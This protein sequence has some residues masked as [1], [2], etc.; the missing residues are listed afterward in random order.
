RDLESQLSAAREELK[1]GK[2]E[3]H[4]AHE[5]M[6]CRLKAQVAEADR[7]LQDVITEA[8]GDCAVLEHQ[9][10][11]MRAVLQDTERQLKETKA[12]LDVLNADVSG[13]GEELK[14]MEHELQNAWAVE[15]TLNNDLGTSKEEISGYKTCL[16]DSERLVKGFLQAATAF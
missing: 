6:D 13:L 4:E 16:E 9:L 12:G 14:R 11:R 3:L 5:E 15:G 1:S 2:H 8:D 7:V 10:F